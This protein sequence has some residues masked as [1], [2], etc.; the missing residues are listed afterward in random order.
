[1]NAVFTFT[2]AGA[3]MNTLVENVS[4]NAIAPENDTDRPSATATV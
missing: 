3:E 2:A 4:F 1:M